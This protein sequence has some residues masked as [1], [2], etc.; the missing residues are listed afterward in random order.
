MK[1]P[2]SSAFEHAISG[3]HTKSQVESFY[4]MHYFKL[5]D[6]SIDV[7]LP[8]RNVLINQSLFERSTRPYP[9]NVKRISTEASDPCGDFTRNTKAEDLKLSWSL[10]GCLFSTGVCWVAATMNVRDSDLRGVMV[11]TLRAW[12][13]FR[14]F[15]CLRRQ[16][17]F[18]FGTGYGTGCPSIEGRAWWCLENHRSSKPYSELRR[19]TLLFVT[20]YAVCMSSCVKIHLIG[21]LGL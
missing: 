7:Y 16:R 17:N 14:T 20:F 2:A 15:C 4:R 9:Y 10:A 8:R 12:G 3:V 11:S 1:L 6:G 13:C 5:A 18:S 21:I 19:G